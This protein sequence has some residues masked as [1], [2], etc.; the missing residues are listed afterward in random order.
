MDYKNNYYRKIDTK[1]SK[2]YHFCNGTN[3]V[4]HNLNF[5]VLTKII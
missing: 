4:K 5:L 1:D 2:V 3:N